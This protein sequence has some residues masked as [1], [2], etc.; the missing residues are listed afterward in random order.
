MASRAGLVVTV[1]SA[2]IHK[3]HWPKAK[4]ETKG[5]ITWLKYRERTRSG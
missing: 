2:G 4:K 3:R 1:F 5:M